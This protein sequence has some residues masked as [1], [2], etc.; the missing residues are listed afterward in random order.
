[1]I[2]GRRAPHLIPTDVRGD[3]FVERRQVAVRPVLVEDIELE[4]VT[5]NLEIVEC[6]HRVWVVA[7]TAYHAPQLV[8]DLLDDKELLRRTD[9]ESRPHTDYILFGYLRF[10][11]TGL[12]VWQC[13][14]AV[15][16]PAGRG[17]R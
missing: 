16:V 3:V 7:R 15:G 17:T 4:R 13:V 11:R 5:F 6:G 14:P 8:A 10:P 2:C 1:M 9:A 12:N